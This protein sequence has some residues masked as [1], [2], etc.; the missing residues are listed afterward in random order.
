MVQVYELE[1]ESQ[2]QN[3][4]ERIDNSWDKGKS[5]LGVDSRKLRTNETRK[6]TVSC[7]ETLNVN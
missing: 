5:F 3:V 2:I 7:Q 1:K 6:L 4:V